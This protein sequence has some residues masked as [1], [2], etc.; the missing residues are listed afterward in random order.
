VDGEE[1]SAIPDSVAY[2]ILQAIDADAQ[3]E[4]LTAYYDNRTPNVTDDSPDTKPDDSLED[5]GSKIYDWNDLAE[6]ESNK[7]TDVTLENNLTP[8]TD[9]YDSI[10]GPD[11]NGGEGFH[12]I[13]S[14]PRGG[15]SEPSGDAYDGEFDGQGNVIVG[16]EQN[17][18]KESGW[19][20]VAG[21]FGGVDEG[22]IIKNVGVYGKIRGNG[23]DWNESMI[24]LLVSSTNLESSSSS[25]RIENCFAVGEIDIPDYDESRVGGLVGIFSNSDEIEN[26]YSVADIT[27][28]D[29]SFAI[30]GFLGQFRDSNNVTTCWASGELNDS[31]NFGGLV[32]INSESESDIVDSYWDTER[33][34][35]DTSQGGTGL[36]TD[37]MT[38]NDAPDNMGGF[39]FD[40][41]WEV[42]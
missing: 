6:L 29:T 31:E 27:I 18:P 38:G 24:G 21:I 19:R 42:P 32:G 20:G 13:G 34:G 16:F 1:I 37:E 7:S 26:C 8:D 12:S 5:G 39:D 2:P 22:G 14:N 33:T 4:I 40:D 30:G 15:G 35:V 9:G 41:I 10:A 11:A 25:T 28:Q 23:D 17:E 3:R 36:T